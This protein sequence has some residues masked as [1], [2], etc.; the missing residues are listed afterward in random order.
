MT[1]G[2]VV[3][4]LGA[5]DWSGTAGDGLRE[6]GGRSILGFV[7][8][9]RTLSGVVF[10]VMGML[11]YSFVGVGYEFLVH[12]MPT[13]RKLTQAQVGPRRSIRVVHNL[14]R[15]SSSSSS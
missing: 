12:G 9:T 5:F 7:V 10:I 14:F 11:S 4:G 13:E 3:R 6:A 2:I 8:D 15:L 1:V